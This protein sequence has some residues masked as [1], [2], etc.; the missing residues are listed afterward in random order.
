MQGIA[1][2]ITFVADA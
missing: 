1:V 2:T